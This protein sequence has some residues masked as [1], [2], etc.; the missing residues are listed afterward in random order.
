MFGLGELLGPQPVREVDPPLGPA[1]NAEED[2]GSRPVL[3]AEDPGAD[4]STEAHL[5]LKFVD[6]EAPLRSDL[7]DLAQGGHP[8]G[9]L[10]LG[11]DEQEYSRM[12]V[13]SIRGVS[14]S[15]PRL[16]VVFMTATFATRLA[17]A[18]EARGWSQNKLETEAGLGRGRINKLLK[19]KGARTDPEVLDL[20][21]RTLGV[22][23]GWLATGRGEMEE[24]APPAKTLPRPA[25]LPMPMVAALDEA[26]DPQRHR[27][28]DAV[29]VRDLLSS[30]L[31]LTT[32]GEAKGLARALL[33]AAAILRERQIEV[34]KDSVFEAMA[35]RV[36][37]L[38]T[39]DSRV[40]PTR[41]PSQRGPRSAAG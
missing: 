34:T 10:L 2:R 8:R 31:L 5:A 19:S 9:R 1:T 11:H 41:P 21:A 26:Y 6:R 15:S 4:A 13:L 25:V 17:L 37:E 35:L 38:E 24:T 22:S 23:P 20:L 27:V 3:T 40:I 36:A 32:P 30:G 16:R 7:I 12:G 39:E 33:D 28:S 14:P 18:L 29:A